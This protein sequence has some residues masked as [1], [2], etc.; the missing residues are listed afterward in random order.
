MRAACRPRSSSS[1]MTLLT[2]RSASARTTSSSSISSTSS[3][4][5]SQLRT[6]RSRLW[7][8]LDRTSFSSNK[9]LLPRHKVPISETSNS[10]LTTRRL[11]VVTLGRLMLPP[12]RANPR[13][14]RRQ[15]DS[16][17]QTSTSNSKKSP[18]SVAPPRRRASKR[19][20]RCLTTG[21]SSQ[22]PPSATRSR[23]RTQ[24]QTLSKQV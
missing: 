17:R 15:I 20:K 1:I 7:S 9:N 10:L 6:C 19:S 16:P 3:R 2:T 21:R 11:R 5:P 4:T 12:L 22:A 14:W 8:M 18:S 13:I 24:P 23:L